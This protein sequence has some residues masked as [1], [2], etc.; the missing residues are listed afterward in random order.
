MNGKRSDGV[1]NMATSTRVSPIIDIMSVIG[2]LRTHS[3]QPVLLT[4]FR[5]D[6]L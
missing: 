3:Q 2:T 6:V 1:L 5:H 4:Y